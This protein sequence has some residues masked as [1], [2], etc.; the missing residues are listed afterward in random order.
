MQK[1]WFLAVALLAGCGGSLPT[2]DEEIRFAR[3]TG[4]LNDARAAVTHTIDDSSKFVPAA[5]DAMDKY[6]V[7]ATIF[8]STRRDPIAGLWPRLNQAIENGH[9]VGAHS[10]THR[11]QWPDTAEFCRSAYDDEEVAGSRDDILENTKQPYVWSWCYPCGNCAGYDFVHRALAAA[12]YVTA[13]TYPGEEQDEHNVPDL[14]GWAANPYEAAYTQVVQKKGGIARSGRTDVAEINAKFDEV[15]RSGGIYSFLS[16][17]QW[18]D[19]GP[20]DFYEQH[21]KHIGGRNDVWY[22]PMGPLYTYRSVLE[23]SGVRKVA[24]NRFS[25]FHTLDRRIYRNAI[26]LEFRGV[27]E[28][29]RAF[30]HDK[31]LPEVQAGPTTRWDHEFFRRDGE[32]VF[33]TVKPDAMVEFR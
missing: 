21:L 20:E 12:G 23:K 22:V 26:T 3:I 15:Y 13:R 6:G 30:A 19:F 4:Y 25:V 16:H 28:G 31:E 8:V 9:E 32:R 10:R 2:G 14:Q 24:A 17:P 33:V 1:A 27:P 5:I 18:L 11:C 29:V 7:K